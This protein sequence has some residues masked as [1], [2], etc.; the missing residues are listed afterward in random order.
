MSQGRR[1]ATELNEETMKRTKIMILA[2]SALMLVAFTAAQADVI[3][4][5]TSPIGGNTV[6]WSQLGSAGAVLGHAFSASAANGDVVTGVFAAPNSNKGELVQQG[7]NWN[8]N[9]N[10]GEYAVWTTN[11]GP[12]TF[13]A[14]SG[15]SYDFVGAYFQQNHFGAFTA[16]LEAFNGN[17]LLGTVSLAG[18][19]T[20]TPGTAI[21]IGALDKSGPN[22]TKWVFTESTGFVH[23]F[24][25]GTMYLNTPEPSTLVLLGSGLIG[26]AGIARRRMSK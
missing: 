4:L 24:A 12:V 18:N 13:S 5:Q 20:S 9:F 19:S 17:T 25:I 1:T 15:N 23:D 3:V 16:M 10:T 14:F 11:H 21:F 2:L 7:T 22:I 8:G 6:D 26:L